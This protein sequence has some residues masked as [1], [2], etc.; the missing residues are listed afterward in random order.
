MI[1]KLGCK[2]GIVTMWKKLS[3]KII[4]RKI[5]KKIVNLVFN[6]N[7]WKKNKIKNKK[8]NI[9]RLSRLPSQRILER[10]D[11]TE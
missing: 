5:K 3:L 7:L 8:S 6:T 1:Q 2:I 4:E 10:R 11:V 9:I